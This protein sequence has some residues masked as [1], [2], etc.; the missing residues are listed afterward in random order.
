MLDKNGFEK[1]NVDEFREFIKK[2]CL[3]KYRKIK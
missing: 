3:L 1:G 2:K